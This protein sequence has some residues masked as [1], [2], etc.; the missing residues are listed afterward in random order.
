MLPPLCFLGYQMLSWFSFVVPW[1]FFC[2]SSFLPRVQ[3]S[4]SASEHQVPPAWASPGA[5]SMPLCPLLHRAG[6]AQDTPGSFSFLSGWE[7]MEGGSLFHLQQQV[8]FK[9]FTGVIRRL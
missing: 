5:L 1:E 2:C 3:H 6:K 4:G 8:V 7:W 9:L